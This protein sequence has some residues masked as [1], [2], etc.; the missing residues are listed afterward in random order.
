MMNPVD[1]I[2]KFYGSESVAIRTN[3]SRLLRHGA[4]AETGRLM[5]LAVDQGFEHGPMRSFSHNP[6]A[7]D[8]DYHFQMAYDAGFSGYTAPL[9]WLQNSVDKFVGKVPLILKLNSSNSLSRA[10]LEPDQAVTASVDDAVRLGCVGIG[11]TLYPGSD[12]NLDLIRE[13]GELIAE[14]RSKGLITIIWSYARG[15]DLKKEDET[16]VDIVAYGAHMACLLGAHIVKVKIPSAHV[17]LSQHKAM[18]ESIPLQSIA[19]RVRHVVQCCFQGKRI[20]IFSGGD[21]KSDADLLNDVQSVALGGGFGSIIGRNIFQRPRED[22]ILR[23]HD[24]ITIL[25]TRKN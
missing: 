2:L 3:L 16:A 22:A 21:T 12:H 17:A 10:G 7:M 11:L 9:G 24:M 8:P 1:N 20:V 15:G 18:Y 5:I 13:A 6:Q 19:D 4:L 14:A 23:I 25:K